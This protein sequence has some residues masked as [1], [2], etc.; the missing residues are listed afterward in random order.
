MKIITL[1][2]DFGTKDS[3]IAQMKGIA[4]S[5][6]NARIIDITHDITPQ[7]IREAA[8][9][10]R[11]AVPYYPIGT[12]HVVVVD[13]EVGSNRKG[14]VIT[15]KKHILIGPD[16]GVLMPAAHYLSE[17]K[18][19]EIINRNYFNKEQSN[20]FHGRDIFM[21]IAAHI[22]NGVPFDQ[23]GTQTTTYVDLDFGKGELYQDTIKGKIIYIDHFGN[24]ITN[25]SQ[26]LIDSTVKI[27][28][29]KKVTIGKNQIELPLVK[30]YSFVKKQGL[31]MTIGSS[32]FLEISINQGNAARKLAVK[33]DDEVTIQLN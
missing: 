5:I 3:Y 13:P 7:N 28:E 27:G 32:N 11:T 9:T 10:L 8:Y 17:F 20:T 14:L 4:A 25:I 29:I 30:S 19:Y 31:L 1:L 15:T 21:P 26:S 24:I 18:I 23:I 33:E 12:T 2:T 16:N 6:T 22:T